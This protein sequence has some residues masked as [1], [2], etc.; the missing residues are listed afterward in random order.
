M[1]DYTSFIEVQF[2]V[3][4]VSKE[5]YKE[6][7]AGAS[8]TLTGLGKWWGRKPLV[9][10]RAALLGL[11]MPA[12]EDP[13]KDMEIFLKIMTMDERGLAL[14]KCKSISSPALY[15]H[16]TDEERRQFFEKGGASAPKIKKGVDRDD[17]RAFEERV[18]GRMGYDEKLTYCKRPEEVELSDEEEWEK[19]N[20][21]LG[22]KARSLKELV[23]E[24]GIRRFGKVPTVGDCF[25]GGGSVPF[26]AARMGLDVFA[27]D[28]NPIA[29]LLTWG[30]LHING[31]SDEEIAKLREFQRKVY[32][33][34]DKQITEWGIE[35][36]EKGHRANAFLYCIEAR[37]PECGWKVPL[38]PT[39]VIGKKTNTVAL[40]NENTYG[41]FDFVIKTGASEK[42]LKEAEKNITATD[43]KMYCPHCGKKTPMAVVRGDK[44][45]KDGGVSSGLRLWERDDMVPREDDVFQERLYCIR[46]EDGKGERYYSA[47]NKYDLD[48][49]RKV[50][51]LLS[52]RFNDWREKGYLPDA[53]IEPG[54]K[55]D[56]PIRTRWTEPLK[57]E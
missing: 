57:L 30:A 43:N 2:P 41:G 38:S 27:S 53:M 31:A 10:V 11:L 50:L 6:R 19:I 45:G 7:K 8:Q 40:L 22:T 4:R 15:A 24:L 32:D 9:M 55:T 5:S 13:E 36:N 26:E 39:W 44:P 21:H 51:N 48:R 25:C 18:F 34:A 54:E 49:E 35:H 37:C 17:K 46:W 23:R 3:S 16:A 42:E 20:A 1:P 56:E 12:G 33:L 52:E 14:R 47:P 29:A 28:L